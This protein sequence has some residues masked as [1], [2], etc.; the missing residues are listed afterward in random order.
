MKY[1]AT[2]IE[3]QSSL[4]LFPQPGWSWMQSQAYLFEKNGSR[5]RERENRVQVNGFQDISQSGVQNKYRTNSLRFWITIH[6]WKNAKASIPFLRYRRPLDFFG[7]PRFILLNSSCSAAEFSILKGREDTTCHAMNIAPSRWPTL[8]MAALSWPASI[9]RHLEMDWSK[10]QGRFDR[11][12]GIGIFLYSL[13]GTRRR[14]K[15]TR[16]WSISFF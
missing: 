6:R 11:G 1:R 3:F 16:R 13:G 15:L 12:G 10:E 2:P 7:V 5:A 9:L 8:E 14:C 4:S